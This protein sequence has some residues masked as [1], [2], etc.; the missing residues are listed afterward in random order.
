METLLEGKIELATT[1]YTTEEIELQDGSQ[2]TLKPLTIKNLRK[3]MEIM[4]GFETAATEDEGFEVCLD[5][6]A[7]CL[8]TERPEFWEEG[9]HTEQFEEV[10]DLPTIYKVLDVCG[11][12]K[13]NDP[14]LLAAATEALGK[15]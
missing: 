13:L 10:A 7:L 14:N 15:D 6:A 3:F 9:K 2:I 11:G 8:K 12:I 4:K 1:V 5:A